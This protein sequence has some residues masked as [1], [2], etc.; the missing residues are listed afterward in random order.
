MPLNAPYSPNIRG[1]ACL[2][3]AV[4]LDFDEGW[5]RWSNFK[6][7]IITPTFNCL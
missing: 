3:V 4:K 6:M 5:E 7:G 1:S 2:L